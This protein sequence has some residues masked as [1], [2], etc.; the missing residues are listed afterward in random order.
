MKSSMRWFAV[1]LGCVLWLSAFSARADVGVFASVQI[2]AEADFHAPLATHGTWVEVDSYGRCWRPSGVVVG[3]Q[4]YCDGYWVWTDCG[5]YWVSD[6]PWGWACYHYGHWVYHSRHGWIWMPGI[7]WA[8]AW[9]SWRVGAGYVGWAPMPPRARFFASAPAPPF[10]FVEVGRFH[11]PVRPSTVIVNN[12]TIINKTTVINNMR[13]E[14]RTFGDATPRKVMINEGPGRAE[15]EKAT[16]NK[17]RAV[18]IQEAIRQTPVPKAMERRTVEPRAKESPATDSTRPQ[19]TTER[20]PERVEKPD[21]PPK[22]SP[23]TKDDS[24]RP[25]QAPERK[26]DPEFPP[27]QGPPAKGKDPSRDTI[28][29]L[30]GRPAAPDSAPE[31]PSKSGKGKGKGRKHN[32]HEP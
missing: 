19:P 32:P 31:D 3:W 26:P 22:H 18:T 17:V 21:A 15:M 14:T 9:V 5:W 4:P 24:D 29:P 20:K 1:W 2:R 10:V 8:P 25:K 7:E 6:E 23:T 12:T 13:Q 30:P 11:E 27:R 28:D 16:G